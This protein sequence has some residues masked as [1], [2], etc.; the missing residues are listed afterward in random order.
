[1]GFIRMKNTG[2]KLRAGKIVAAGSNYLD[3]A[4]EMGSPRPDAPVLFLKPST[5]IIH[6]GEPI[7]F[8]RVGAVLHHEVELGLLVGRD[9]TDVAVERAHECVAGYLLALDLTLRD[10]QSDAKKRGLPWS[11]AKGFDCA[12]P[13]SEVLPTEQLATLR[14][15]DLGL[16]V[17][18]E[19]RQRGN[20]RDMLWGPE[21][22]V[23]VASR[24][25]TLE[26]GDIVLTGTPAGVGPLERG[27]SVKAWLGNLLTVS[28]D[29][30]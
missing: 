7:V 13:V 30:V 2:D 18:G 21:E 22:L 19:K 8:P 12:C 10:L 3:H 6:E 11:T 24:Y 20:T 25:F 16:D 1:M 9:C 15:L 23:A 27:D 5:S 28:F 26:R 17:N 29:V 14:A 4:K